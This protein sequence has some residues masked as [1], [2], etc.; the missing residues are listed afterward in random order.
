MP[1]TKAALTDYL[2]R[3]NGYAQQLESS[4]HV[5][6]AALD[7]AQRAKDLLSALTAKAAAL[8][9]ATDPTLVGL[10]ELTS[11]QFTPDVP[12]VLS[13]V[14]HLVGAYSARLDFLKTTSP[15]PVGATR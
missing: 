15:P 13:V 8:G 2:A 6:R 3:L 4:Q 10:A 12:V 11:Q 9:Q 5:Y 14:N 1:N 7:E